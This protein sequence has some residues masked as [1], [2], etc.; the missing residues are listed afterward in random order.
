MKVNDSYFN[1]TKYNTPPWRN[2][3]MCQEV[4]HTFGLDHQD[5]VFNNFNLGTCMDYTNAPAGGGAYGPSNQHPNAHD[6]E[7]LASIYSHLETAS[8]AA[9]APALNGGRNDDP[10]DG[11]A[12]WG[13]AVGRDGDGRANQFELDLRNG[14]KKLTHVFWAR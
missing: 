8:T 10:G 7:M 6:Y 5:E 4:G 14:Q 13:R 11:P 12:D 1:T 9:T 3:V 2:L